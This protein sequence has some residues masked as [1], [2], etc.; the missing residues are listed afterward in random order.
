MGK[1]GEKAECTEKAVDILSPRVPTQLLIK[2]PLFFRIFFQGVRANFRNNGLFTL[3]VSRVCWSGVF[4]QRTRTH[5][6]N[7]TCVRVCKYI[8]T[9]EKRKCSFFLLREKCLQVW[10]PFEAL[11]TLAW[12]S[13]A[14]FSLK[15]EYNDVSCLPNVQILI[16]FCV[17]SRSRK[18]GVPSNWSWMSHWITFKCELA[19]ILQFPNF[20]K[21]QVFLDVWEGTLLPLR[22]C[23]P[24]YL[25]ESNKS[26]SGGGT[27]LPRVPLSVH[28]YIALRIHTQPLSKQTVN[29]HQLQSWLVREK[30]QWQKV[31]FWSM[32]LL[33]NRA[34]SPPLLPPLF[35]LQQKG[36]I[37]KDPRHRR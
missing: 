7:D 34:C 13:L 27:Y 37:D 30:I 3:A 33:F 14:A 21:F 29:H 10:I 11:F 9:C 18:A 26:V 4:L 32:S 8:H 24:L 25:S 6:V 5:K 28:W 35:F 12:I 16:V 1:Q 36:A 23:F 17:W 2:S 19:L 15:C 20:I 22:S 31:S